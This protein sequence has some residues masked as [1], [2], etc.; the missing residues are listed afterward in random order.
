MDF[1]DNL[2]REMG[3]TRREVIESLNVLEEHNAITTLRSE[4]GVAGVWLN[5]LGAAVKFD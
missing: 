3:W 5:A 4:H 1:V 2:A